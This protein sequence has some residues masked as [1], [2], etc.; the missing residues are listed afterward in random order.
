[1]DFATVTE[2]AC[3]ALVRPVV[4]YTSHQDRVF[5]AFSWLAD[6]NVIATPSQVTVRVCPENIPTP[7]LAWPTANVT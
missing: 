3:V 7:V 4:S 2:I 6:L 1:M 5:E